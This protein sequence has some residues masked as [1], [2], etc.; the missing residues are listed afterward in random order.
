MTPTSSEYH[1]GN[2][3]DAQHRQRL[4]AP[5]DRQH[6]GQEVWRTLALVMSVSRPAI[7]I[8]PIPTYLVLF[9]RLAA[10]RPPARPVGLL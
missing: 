3:R 7:D 1:S 5:Y 4:R 10:N 9:Q 8:P 2:E 6:V